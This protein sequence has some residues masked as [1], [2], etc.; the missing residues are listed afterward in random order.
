VPL[1]TLREPDLALMSRVLGNAGRARGEL[2]SFVL[3]DPAFIEGL[4]DAGRSDARRWLDRHPGLWCADPAHD[5]GAGVGD[6][7]VLREHQVIE[8]FREA[9]SRR[10]GTPGST[11]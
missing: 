7:S 1:G 2:L 11:R 10:P 8:E 5:L 3:F 6:P 4:I 9:R